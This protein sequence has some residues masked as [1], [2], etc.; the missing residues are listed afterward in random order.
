MKSV[1]FASNVIFLTILVSLAGCDSDNKNRP[2]SEANVAKEIQPK[3]A[4]ESVA[5]RAKARWEARIA[6][7]WKTVYSFMSP[8]YRSTHPYEI[9]AVQMARSPLVYR[10]V[11]VENVECQDNERCTV[12]MN[13]ESEYR[14]GQTAFQGQVSSSV[15]EERWIKLGDQWWFGR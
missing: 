10:K 1:R 15:V 7:D 2:V 3:T 5:A 8:G 12:K 13:V 9:F 14:G 4:E 6:K 11:A